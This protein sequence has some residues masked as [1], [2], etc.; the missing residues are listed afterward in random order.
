LY[1]HYLHHTPGLPE[2]HEF[3]MDVVMMGLSSI[4]ALAGIGIAYLLYVVSPQISR[5]LKL[6]FSIPW[7]ISNQGLFIDWCGYKFI[8]APLRTLATICELFDR[9]VIDTLVDCFGFIPGLLGSIIRPV[10]NGVVQ[11]YA[12]VM[13]IGLVVCLISILRALS[14]TM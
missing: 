9:W 12:T 6:N 3:P 13:M 2:G 7:E 11:N 14:G 4:L 10:Q 1:A 8:A 5:N